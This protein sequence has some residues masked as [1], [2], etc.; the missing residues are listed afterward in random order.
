MGEETKVAKLASSGLGRK[1]VDYPSA[2]NPEQ[3][4]VVMHPG[5]P[6]LVLAGAGS[7][8]TRTVVY[9]V[10]RLLEDGVEPSSILMLTFTNRAARE[11]LTRVEILLGRDASPVVGGTFHSVGNRILRRYGQRL[12]YPPNYAILDREDAQELMG[13]AATDL[14]P[15][16]P[17]RRLPGAAVL[18]EI[19]SLVLNTG[20]SLPA[21]VEWKYPQ[22]VQ[23]QEFMEAVFRRYVERKRQAF[24]MDYDDLLLNWLL[25]LRQHH[26]VRQALAIRF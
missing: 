22:F 21:V 15:Q 1:R 24:L 2:L 8:K 17:G 4:A 11:M 9:R 13:Q 16:H 26:D 5:G 3:L 18:L 7:G 14:L 20:R 10:A 6:M 25:L 12:G 23:D 19:Y